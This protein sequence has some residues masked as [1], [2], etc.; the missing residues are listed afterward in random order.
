MGL[1]EYSSPR[2]TLSGDS[3][4]VK[5]LSSFLAW[6]CN[7]DTKISFDS[8]REP[9][10]FDCH[11]NNKELLNCVKRAHLVRDQMIW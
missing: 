6:F 8:T 4:L 2:N 1:L 11:K 10:R 3:S 5:D 9:I 7:S